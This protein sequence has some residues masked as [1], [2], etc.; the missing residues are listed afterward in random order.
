MRQILCDIMTVFSVPVG[1]LHDLPVLLPHKP[2]KAVIL[3]I[4]RSRM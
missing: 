3:T 2:D 4:S 1:L